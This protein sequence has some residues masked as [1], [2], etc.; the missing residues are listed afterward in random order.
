[1]AAPSK[2]K[3]QIILESLK[4]NPNV[5]LVKTERYSPIIEVDTSVIF[6]VAPKKRL[7]TAPELQRFTESLVPRG[8]TPSYIRKFYEDKRTGML[9]FGGIDFKEGIGKHTEITEI[10]D[11]AA[12]SFVNSDSAEKDIP[13]RRLERITNIERVIRINPYPDEIY[14]MDLGDKLT[15]EDY[16]HRVNKITLDVYKKRNA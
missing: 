8:L 15:D 14:V 3:L 11:W 16:L 2:T 10:Y 7:Y 6:R 4:A 9:N 12:V 1:M 13:E 5:V